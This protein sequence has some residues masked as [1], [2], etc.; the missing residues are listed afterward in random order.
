MRTG[1]RAVASFSLFLLLPGLAGC[2]K[3]PAAA[4][5]AGSVTEIVRAAA[6]SDGPLETLNAAARH[7]REAA[8]LNAA[9][10]DPDPVVRRAAAYVAALWADDAGDVAALTPRLAD[11]DAAVRAMVA[12]SLAGLGAA[13]ARGTLASLRA[14][15]EPMPW[16]DPPM[17]VGAFASAAL[18]A[19]DAPPS[20][21]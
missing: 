13:G 8:E 14:S 11:T 12:G 21:R 19:I 16:S 17:T 2:T 20:R 9:L 7:R 6:G 4:A 3:Q 10:A 15:V 5:P 18:A 1:S